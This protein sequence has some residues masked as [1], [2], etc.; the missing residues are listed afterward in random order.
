MTRA[1][2]ILQRLDQLELLMN[3]HVEVLEKHATLEGRIKALED[4]IRMI[5]G[6]E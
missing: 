4:I 5:V 2:T 6:V 1:R 3:K